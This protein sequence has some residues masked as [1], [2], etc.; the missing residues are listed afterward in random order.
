MKFQTQCVHVGVNKD[1]QYNSCIT[2]IYPS[3]TFYW[4]SLDS[5]SGYDYTRSA[6]PTRDA[7]HENLAALESG[8]DARATCTGMAAINACMHLFRPGDHVIAPYDLYGG[9]F[10]LMSELFTNMG[11]RFSFVNERDLD[12][13]RAAITPETKG[14]WIETPSNPLLNVSDIA[15]LADIAREHGIISIA[16]NTFLS[17]ALQR[18][19]EL[20]CDIVMHSTTKYLN[21]HSDVVGGAVISKSE[22]HA[23]KI[24]HIV[25]ALGL[26]ASP[27]D[28]WLVLRGIKTLGPRMRAHEENAMALAQMLADHPKVDRVYYPGLPDHA[29]HE[30]AKRQQDGFGGMLSFE[31]R[32]GRPAAETLFAALHHFALAESLG[33]VESLIEYPETMSHASMTDEAR[34]EAGITDCT[35]R[36][37]AGIEAAEDL[38]ADMA[39][40]LDRV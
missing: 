13:V 34:K 4:N 23:A 37:S 11:L 28:C 26:G 16:D 3:S 7:L 36:V 24:G 15:A 6:N 29:D 9:T 40:A 5:N 22:E 31:L 17:P 33:G 27:F 18:P 38:T 21:G 32:G 2:P 12:A 19:L 35:I 10:R 1:T 8:S 30:L 25:N 14:L 39:A 20:G